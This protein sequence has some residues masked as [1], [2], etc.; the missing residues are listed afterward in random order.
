M[1]WIYPARRSVVLVFCISSG[2]KRQIFSGTIG[3]NN[4]WKRVHSVSAA[5]AEICCG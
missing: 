3:E 5:F 4:S 1:R 2:L